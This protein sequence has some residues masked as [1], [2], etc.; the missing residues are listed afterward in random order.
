MIGIWAATHA[1]QDS[2]STAP[3]ERGK[4][5]PAGDHAMDRN[6][7]MTVVGRFFSGITQYAFHCRLGVADP[8][9]VSYV[10]ELLVRFVARDEVFRLRTPTGKRLDQVAD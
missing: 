9:L 1:A 10:A 8:K 5:A 6:T 7:S 3:Q 4:L 2:Q